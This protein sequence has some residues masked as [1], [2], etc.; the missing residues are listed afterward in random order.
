M[1]DRQLLRTETSVASVVGVAPESLLT[2]PT[3]SQSSLPSAPSIPSEA[4]GLFLAGPSASSLPSIVILPGKNAKDRLNDSNS[5]GSGDSPIIGNATC[6]LW[7]QDIHLPKEELTK[8]RV[9][10]ELYHPEYFNRGDVHRGQ[11]RHG[12]SIAALPGG[13]C[14]YWSSSSGVLCHYDEEDHGENDDNNNRDGDDGN[15][16]HMENRDDNGAVLSPQTTMAMSMELAN[17]TKKIRPNVSVRLPLE[18]DEVVTHVTSISFPNQNRNGHQQFYGTTSSSFSSCSVALVGTSLGRTWMCAIAAQPHE[19]RARLLFSNNENHNGDFDDESNNDAS[20]GNNRRRTL[21]GSIYGSIFTPRKGEGNKH[22]KSQSSQYSRVKRSIRSDIGNG[23]IGDGGVVKILVAPPTTSSSNNSTSTGY[24]PP[25]TTGSSTLE[26]PR[27]LAKL[28]HPTSVSKSRFTDRLW[29][30]ADADNNQGSSSSGGSPNIFHVVRQHGTVETWSINES[31]SQTASSGRMEGSGMESSTG[32]GSYEERRIGIFDIGE[33]FLSVDGLSSRIEVMNAGIVGG[34]SIGSTGTEKE[35]NKYENNYGKRGTHD[36]KVRNGRTDGGEERSGCSIVLAVRVTNDN[37]NVDNNEEDEI[38][39]IDGDKEES[40]GPKL[41]LVRLVT[42]A[43]VESTSPISSPCLRLAGTAWLD[44]FP[45]DIVSP[46]SPLSSSPLVCV[47]LAMGGTGSDN[48][49]TAYSIWQQD[50]C[51]R[52]IHHEDSDMTDENLTT[53]AIAKPRQ[54]LHPV[55]VSATRFEESGTTARSNDVDL[56]NDIVPSVVIGAVAWD[57]TTDGCVILASTGV[58]VGVRVL[59]PS[60]S[61]GQHRDHRVAFAT[62]STENEDRVNDVSRDNLDEEE[63][64]VVTGHI[65]SS[66]KMISAQR[67]SSSSTMTVAPGDENVSLP[68]SIRA[69]SDEI[70]GLAVSSASSRLAEGTWWGYTDEDRNSNGSSDINNDNSTIGTGGGFGNS[71]AIANG[72]L[73]RAENVLRTRL[74]SHTDLI[75]FCLRVGIYKRVSANER[76]I[77]RN[78]GEMMQAAIAIISAWRD[79]LS[80]G[81][82]GWTGEGFEE[83]GESKEKN[84]DTANDENTSWNGYDNSAQG[85]SQQFTDEIVDPET[86][87]SINS[88]LRGLG[89]RITSK[90][91]TAL[92]ALIDLVSVDSSS[93]S[94]LSSPP[95]PRT[96]HLISILISTAFRSAKEY[97]QKESGR[98]YDVEV[99]GGCGDDQSSVSYPWTSASNVLSL[100]EKQLDAIRAALVPTR[101]QK[102]SYLIKTHVGMLANAL[103]DGYR[104]I[105]PRLRNEGGYDAAKRLAV[106]LLKDTCD[107]D[108]RNRHRNQEKND[109]EKDYKDDQAFI[110]SL[111]HGFFDLVVERCQERCQFQYNDNDKSQCPYQLVD[112]MAGVN[113]ERYSGLHKPDGVT[114]FLT[115]LPFCEFVLRW[116]VDRDMHGTAMRLGTAACPGVLSSYVREDERMSDLRWIRDVADGEFDDASS[117]LL[118]LASSLDCS[119]NLKKKQNNIN[120]GGLG[121]F[122]NGLDHRKLALSLAKLTNIIGSYNDQDNNGSVARSRAKARGRRVNIIHSNSQL[123]RAQ[124]MLAEIDQ[125]IAE[126][127][128]VMSSDELLR[129]TLELINNLGER[130]GSTVMSTNEKTV[131]CLAGLIVTSA[132]STIGD[133]DVDREVGEMNDDGEALSSASSL[134]LKNSSTLWARLILADGEEWLKMIQDWS[135]GSDSELAE[136]AQR[137]VFYHVLC[138]FY[139]KGTEGGGYNETVGFLNVPVRARTLKIIG[140]DYQGIETPLNNTIDLALTLL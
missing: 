137:T 50:Q 85:E 98:V 66:F 94:S 138:V 116:Y 3:I 113:E 127:N 129:S 130:D 140:N 29:A 139:D 46:F 34:G 134:R 61:R 39:E 105:N 14:F 21:L 20:E 110:L 89:G 41:Y 62:D 123:C 36:E 106:G 83:Y 51:K 112:M 103:L 48:A 22:K 109:H 10:T 75:G 54:P 117:N 68:P 58:V 71:L 107:N 19:L 97:R 79:Y 119:R 125:D 40:S 38:N 121:T 55:T 33:A 52:N 1:R 131:A 49:V 82:N 12:D 87:A 124:E 56:P 18:V 60:L 99:I 135:S 78:H 13:H 73:A 7:R 90:F 136:R 28:A 133:N 11:L 45:P 77:L 104:D 120:A 17:M 76:L 74:Y 27:K 63:V 72:P 100:L 96:V 35:E 80:A 118:G 132:G 86:C 6:R 115:R 47:G 5:A 32:S 91:S 44:R 2:L 8:P 42:T 65:L 30:G 23:G 114:D 128:D 93:S 111:K 70:V 126:R 95:L 9:S 59:F 4:G 81:S 53:L 102:N 69:A 67:N 57:A 108:H 16:N 31:G 122:R 84:N 88:I 101:S 26:T 43:A 37:D 24:Q 64:R 92:E 15:V 25:Y